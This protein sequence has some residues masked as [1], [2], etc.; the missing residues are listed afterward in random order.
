MRSL[1]V[2]GTVAPVPGER[3]RDKV[4]ASKRKGI[5]MGGAVLLGYRVENRA[6]HVAEEEAEFVRAL[7][8]RY[9]EVGSVVRLKTV[10]DA[11]NLRS[12]VRMSRTG[13]RT[14]GGLTSRG[15]L[16]WILSNPIY[17]GRLANRP[18]LREFL[19]IRKPRRFAGTAGERWIRT[20]D[21]VCRTA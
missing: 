11:E 17:L 10:L 4:A 3:I 7:F 13:G 18:K 20:R 5:W 2:S 8:R 6:L 19:W 12:P 1:L 16:Y 9:L 14:G 15:H 21:T